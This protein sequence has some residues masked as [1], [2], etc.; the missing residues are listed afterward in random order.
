MSNTVRFAQHEQTTFA[1]GFVFGEAGAY[2]RL[3]GRASFAVDPL[4]PAQA[5]VVDLA[6]ADVFLTVSCHMSP[7]PA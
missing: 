1:D 5:A 2:E 3:K 7:V 4:A 6:L